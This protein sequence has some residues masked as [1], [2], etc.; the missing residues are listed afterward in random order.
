MS[1]RANPVSALVCAAL[2]LTAPVSGAVTLQDPA[3][4]HPAGAKAQDAMAACKAVM[5]D[6]E[7]MMADMKA[8]DQRLD[9]LVAKMNAASG[10]EKVDAMAAVVTEMVAQRTAMRDG[11]MKM[12]QGMM[13]HMMEHMH[14]GKESMAMCPMMKHMGGMKP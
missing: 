9:S 11:M 1:H 5:A 14:A 13:S 8:A 12:H 7:Q 10:Q 4:A 6:R 3:H 2:L